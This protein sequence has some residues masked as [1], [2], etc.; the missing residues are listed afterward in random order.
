M[1]V[2]KFEA[3]RVADILAS[4]VEHR[5]YINWGGTRNISES[6]RVKRLVDDDEAE[7]SFGSFAGADWSQG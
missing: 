1:A 7:P 4:R 3:F 2:G 6:K 5:T